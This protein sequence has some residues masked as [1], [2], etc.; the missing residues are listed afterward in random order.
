MPSTYAHYRFG[1]E[2]LN[3]LDAPASRLAETNRALFWI[4]LHGPDI[5]FYYNVLRDTP[6][7]QI[8]HTLHD[9]NAA[10]FFTRAAEIIRAADDFPAGRA[11]LMGYICHFA[12]D[13]C[14]HPYIEAVIRS[15]GLT[16]TEIEADLERQLLTDDG[17]SPIHYNPAAHLASD[18]ETAG[19]I[20]R[21][22][23]TAKV[24][25]V[26]T[27]LRHFRRYSGLLL[28]TCRLKETAVRGI[29]KISGHE[30]ELGGMIMRDR[31]HPGC[32]QSTC[33]LQ[34]IYGDAL[35]L[36]VRLIKNYQAFLD[37][38]EALDP[39]FSRTFGPD[40]TEYARL[41]REVLV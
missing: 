4:G 20:A 14:C 13:S 28:P 18:P 25:Q 19:V 23:P 16:H 5:F 3:R 10:K 35:P 1:N 24:R 21:F 27:A 39:R 11:Y 17:L 33:D 7:G 15:Q 32:V 31:P 29:L 34:K 26:Q 30:K 41:Q 38:K 12:L 6:V 40:E 37:G 2:V 8:G 22:H 9:Q 36:A